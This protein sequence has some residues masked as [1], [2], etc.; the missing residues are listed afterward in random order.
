[1]AFDSPPA[2]LGGK[3]DPTSLAALLHSPETWSRPHGA[4]RIS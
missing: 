1:M 4:P 3:G 2:S